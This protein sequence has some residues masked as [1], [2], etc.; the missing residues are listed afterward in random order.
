MHQEFITLTTNDPFQ[1]DIKYGHHDNITGRAINGYY[2]NK[3]I[4]TKACFNALQN[5]HDQLAPSG[6][7]LLIWDAYR[8]YK[9]VLDF[10]NWSQDHLDNLNKLKT[11]HFLTFLSP[12]K[13]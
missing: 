8:P 13:S 7:C 5:V 4:M 2:A 9:A 11:P 12:N 3:C 10:W 6:Y 1:W